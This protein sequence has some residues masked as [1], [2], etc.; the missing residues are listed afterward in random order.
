MIRVLLIIPRF[1]PYWGG[2]ELRMRTIAEALQQRGFSF[3]VLTR[4]FQWQLPGVEDI[5]GLH[6]VR[7]PAPMPLFRFFA[8]RW[9][10]RHQGDI[11]LVHSFRLDKTGLIGAVAAEKFGLPHMAEAITNEAEKMLL[12]HK[13]RAALV[14]ICDS[15]LIHTL[16]QATTDVL[17]HAG[18]P[19]E[20]IWLRGNAVDTTLYYPGAQQPDGR[21]TVLC[22][23]RL[24]RQK[25]SDILIEAWKGLPPALRATARLVLAGT[26]K[27]E[28]RIRAAAN[29]MDEVVFTGAV[30]KAE[31]P[32]L[33]RS[34]HIYV[35]PSRFEGMSNAILE[36]MAS[37]LP[38]IST[39]IPA[40]RGVIDNGMNGL[41]VPP[42]DVAALRGA[43]I[44]LMEDAG[45][46]AHLG[47]MARA[48]ATSRFALTDLFDDYTHRYRQLAGN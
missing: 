38:I 33:Y 27:W 48:T 1:A 40:N 41:L 30:P 3:T 45:L 21:L 26:G 34:A 36:A 29:D 23:G 31:T 6:I 4:R 28:S 18:L 9:I 15:G 46:R 2:T 12:R 37:G 17:T 10:A 14:A 47:L 24:E 5:G 19:P 8:A 16:G 39:S 7:L 43:L 32:V 35:Q 20:K 22:C 13:G 11:D 44:R 42:D 25:G